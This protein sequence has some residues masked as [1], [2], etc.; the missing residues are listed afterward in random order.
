MRLL[1]RYLVREIAP[2]VAL[3]LVL[4]TSVIF[5]REASRFSE[6]FIV[7]S[8]NGMPTRPLFALIA[9][10][11]PT[12]LVYTVPISLLVGVLVGLGRLSSDSEIT[13]MRASGVSRRRLVYPLLAIGLVAAAA[14]TYI[15][16]TL[17]PASHRTI[18]D[19]KQAR[20]DI[21]YQGIATQI[22]PRVF[23]ESIPG[24]VF[25]IQDVDRQTNEWRNL[26]IA[27]SAAGDDP[28]DVTIYTARAGRLTT[29]SPGVILPELHLYEVQA[30]EVSNSRERRRIEYNIQDAQKLSIVFQTSGDPAAPAEAARPVDFAELEF[31]ALAAH[32]PEPER[33]RS[34]RAELHKRFAVPVTC[35]IFAVIGLA[36]G[37][38]NQ[39]AGRSFGLLLGLILTVLFYVVTIGG[40]KAGRS[41]ALPVWLGVWG[42]NIA[43]AGFGVWTTTRGRL[44][45][46]AQVGALVAEVARR[47]RSAAPAARGGASGRAVLWPRFPRIID[48]LVVTDL[49][50]HVALVAAGLTSV[51]LVF[52]IFEH[53]TEIV[54]NQVPAS[55]V[56]GYVLYL[57]PQVVAYMVP[58]AVLVGVMV[59]F[60]LMAAGSQVVALKAS[61]QSIY[62]LAAPVVA[63]ALA[64]SAALFAVQNFVLPTTNRQQEELRQQIVSGVEPARTVHQ[65]DRQWIFGKENRIF[66]YRHYDPTSDSFAHLS[67]FDLDPAT[68]QITRRVFAS[69]ASWVP[70]RGE[71]L[72]EYGWQRTFDGVRVT[73]A[74]AFRTEHLRIAEAPDYFKRPVSDADK[75]TFGELRR[76]IDELSRSG[77][78]VLDL[79]IDMHAKVAFP[80]T[81]LI[82][83][84]VGLPFAFSVGKRG[85]VYGVAIG[86]AIGLVFWGALGLFTQLGRYEIVPPLL[87]AW[88][89][90][91]LFGAGGVYLFLTTRT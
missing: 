21:V 73:A 46:W 57:T 83:A 65:T 20:G 30:H 59:T 1:N 34:H 68:F 8:R 38:Y 71:W 2:Y 66:Y 50:R 24:K 14:M 53:L 69:K 77:F 89:P 67:I 51:F 16:F 12:V 54:R 13:A 91:M 11:L 60:G 40:E 55:V 52:T 5:L 6:L 10:V 37:V 78:D 3:T 58:L 18:N 39:R 19:L 75:L 90:N 41:G 72:L 62:R 49:G 88:G 29:P 79:R 48:R 9:A 45:R 81:C 26:F 33:E 25:F 15:T 84:F 82:M 7:F 74:D 4:L 70:E 56:V 28:D 87:A 35:V 63:L 80:L 43:F 64:L 32:Q 76:Q 85:A 61:G 31:A 17:A 23:E 36:F 44:P 86:L 47:V 27:E 42:P 22:K